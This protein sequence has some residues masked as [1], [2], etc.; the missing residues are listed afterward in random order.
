[1]GKMLYY[2]LVTFPG[3]NLDSSSCPPLRLVLDT[4]LGYSATACTQWILGVTYTHL[5]SRLKRAFLFPYPGK[6]LFMFFHEQR[7]KLT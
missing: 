4:G 1:M 3:K 7:K 2:A 5:V 6:I